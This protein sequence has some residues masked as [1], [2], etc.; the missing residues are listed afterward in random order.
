[1]MYLTFNFVLVFIVGDSFLML[2]IARAIE[3]IG[4]ACVNVCGMSLIAHVSL[5][6]N[7]GQQ[8]QIHEF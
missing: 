4:S 8:L 3:G 2:F 6:N 1:M 5:Q 7:L